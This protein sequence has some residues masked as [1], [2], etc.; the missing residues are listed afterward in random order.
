MPVLRH[1]TPCNQ[2]PWRR[3]S[4]AGWL[5]ADTPEGFLATT[6]AGVAMPC[7]TAIDYERDDWEEQAEKGPFCAG[8]L[9]F[10]KN[11]CNLPRTPDVAAARAQVEPDHA[12]V[13][14][15]PDQFLAHHNR[16][17]DLA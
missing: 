8:A 17:E 15:R 14:S 2:C 12:A 13:F 11:I 1:K 6:M 4:A 16:L 10:L 5:G 9:V 7:H 3:K